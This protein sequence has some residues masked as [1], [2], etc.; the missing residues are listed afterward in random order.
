MNHLKKIQ[1]SLAFPSYFLVYWRHP[2]P[3]DRWRFSQLSGG[4][5]ET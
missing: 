1:F 3:S 2:A 5:G 4:G